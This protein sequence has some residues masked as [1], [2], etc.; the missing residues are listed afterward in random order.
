MAKR[1]EEL[2]QSRLLPL[3]KSCA[4][5]AA[6]QEPQTLSPKIDSGNSDIEALLSACDWANSPL[7]A[8]D[9]WPQA[10]K[11]SVELMLGARFPMFICWGP[12]FIAVY[13][14]A[15]ITILGSKHPA[16]FGQSLIE[17]W[18]EIQDWLRPALLQVLAGQPLYQE[19]QAFVL[20]RNSG[21]EKT[22]FTFSYSPIK[23]E[24]GINTGVLCIC[25]E[26]T[27]QVL[28]QQEQA[29]R[30][31]FTDALRRLSS[32]DQIFDTTC[33]LLGRYLGVS[34]VLFGEYD[35][36]LSKINYFASYTNEVADKLT[37][38]CLGTEFGNLNLSYL[39]R[40]EIWVTH[41]AATDPRTNTLEMCR[42]LEAS[43][44]YAAVMVPI[45]T[46]GKLV[47]CLFINH[48]N[49]RHWTTPE[50]AL[51]K[52]VAERVESTVERLR[53]ENALHL[54]DGAFKMQVVAERNRLQQLFDQSPGF[55]AIMRGPR[56][57]FETVNQ[58]YYQ[59]VGHRALIG[60]TVRE[61]LPE[62][63]NQGYYELLDSVFV[64]KKAFVGQEMKVRL[65]RELAGPISDAYV[66]LLYQPIFEQDGSVSGIFAQG[67]DVTA[68][69]LARD[70]A[71]IANERWKLV[72]ES[73]GDGVWDWDIPANKVVYSSR[74]KEI[75]G[76]SDSG[77]GDQHDAW[78]S[79][80]HA[81]DARRVIN[82]MQ[83]C[84][85]G[86]APNFH[87][88]YRLRSKDGLWKWVE[89]HGAVVTRDA[90]GRALRVTGT[91]SDI[92][93]KKR[94]ETENWNRANFDTLTGLPNRRLFRD[95]LDESVKKAARSELGLA[96]FFIDLD[97]FKE[98]N[99]LLGH[100]IGDLLLIKAGQRIANS[101]RA[102][103]TV[104]RLGGDEFT[105]ILNDWDEESHIERT[106]QKIIERLGQPF[107]IGQEIIYLSASIGITIYSKDADSSDELIKNADQAMYAAKNAG[108]NR[109]SYFTRAMQEVA[110]QRF[111]LGSDLRQAI[112][113]GQLEVHYQPVVELS[114]G[115][116]IKAEALLRWNH[117]KWGLIAP[118]RFIPIAEE[119]GQIHAIGNW[120]F[121][122]AALCSQRWSAQIGH[123]FQIAINK[124]PA[125]FMTW[126]EDGQWIDHLHTLGLQG[127]SLA[128]EITEGLLLKAFSNVTEKLA[129]Y[130][131]AG[132]ELGLDDFG[133]GYSSM[134]YLK[135]FDIDYLKIDQSFI[136]GITENPEDWAVTESM[137]VM[138]R[139][140]G[141]MVIA[142]GVET[143]AQRTLLV[144]AGCHY[145]QGYLFSKAVPADEFEQLLK[146]DMKRE[147]TQ[148]SYSMRG[149]NPMRQ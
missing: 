60:K 148:R 23:D 19:N 67:H 84:V 33:E 140:L 83:D 127:S 122:K 125:Q 135:T 32:T 144:A 133:T 78:T 89:S 50:I 49:P 113:E 86:A 10:L 101:V 5:A 36:E 147:E 37:A 126:D 13:N 48:C 61:A 87:E 47:T 146:E 71:R 45:K 134:T 143:E 114:S 18:S 131:A 74:W 6:L 82:A 117:P 107:E 129:R 142:E 139:R 53:A 7:G 97:R 138:A 79:R 98:A 106:A 52:D 41:N 124:S 38:S 21:Q 76:Y 110:D 43:H 15:Y 11:T 141:L 121:R 16:A 116:I 68:Y 119:T 70:E 54:L 2:P 92:S 29:F 12:Q 26:T 59:L 42:Q 31:Q 112:G 100:D 14:T 57:V 58:S 95:R 44:I 120:V 108:R 81:K 3:A 40:S 94:A 30:L 137:I 104:A 105:V 39:Q 1:P 149:A 103:D 72:I 56:H 85:T 63:K 90:E 123:P 132:V 8:R 136:S 46:H 20:H 69:K 62:L 88:E 115:R 80:I 66:N 145:G 102:S 34:Q 77:F 64:N 27:G 128:I 25:T 4:D 55:V 17:T 28:A 111:R 22:W 75:L 65:Q 96:L 130:R 99:D 24:R 93:A 109:F 73:T 51:I 91:L 9:T 35:T 118:S